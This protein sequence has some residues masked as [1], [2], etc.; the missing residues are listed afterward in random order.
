MTSRQEGD[1]HERDFF[2]HIGR[3]QC[4][5]IEKPTLANVTIKPYQANY[6]TFLSS[7]DFLNILIIYYLNYIRDRMASPLHVAQI[8]GP[9]VGGG[10]EST[11]LNHYRFLDHSQVQFDFI[12]QDDSTYIPINEINKYGGR[13]YTI[14]SYK[15]LASYMK[16]LQAFYRKLKPDIVHSNMNSLSVFPLMAAKTAGIPIR[17]AHSHSTA[18]NREIKRTIIKNTLRPLSRIYPTHLAACGP[19][20]AKWLFGE[21]AVLQGRV[22]YI[23]N[24]IELQKFQFSSQK[25]LELRHSIG[26]EEEFVVGQIGRFTSQKNQL[27]SIDVFR[28]LLQYLPNAKLVFLGTGETLEDCKKKV[29]DYG[30]NR[31]VL[32]LGLRQDVADWYSAFDT[33]LFPSLYEGLGMVAIEAQ[34]SGLP[35]LASDQVPQEAFVIKEL[36]ST[37]PLNESPQHWAQLLAQESRTRDYNRSMF[38]TAKL[39]QAGYDIQASATSLQKWYKDIS[40]SQLSEH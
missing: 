27:F 30:I 5:T 10:L 8:M 34:A 17:I 4:A 20:A 6:D 21:K 38:S 26:L 15:H 25:R 29:H 14:P 31:S 39:V 23:N 36:I 24:A 19:H 28:A 3:H 33:L 16:E 11:I 18:N 12:I 13:I 22:H 7:F 2:M 37:A 40:V 35:V 1:T 32:F 9:M